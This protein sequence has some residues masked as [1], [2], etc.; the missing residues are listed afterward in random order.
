M[1]DKLKAAMEEF[2]TRRI[3]DLGAD[4]PEAVMDAVTEA[5]S[6]RENLEAALTAAQA[7][8]LRAL[9]NSLD[10]R[11]GEEARYYYSAGFLDAVR[12]LLEWSDV[13]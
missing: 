6:R 1:D 10:V 11:A 13:E 4:A 7:P 5:E 12:F 2:I 9:E 8:L 3:N